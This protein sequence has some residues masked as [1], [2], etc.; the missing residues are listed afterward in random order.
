MTVGGVLEV[1]ITFFFTE[2]IIVYSS[3]GYRITI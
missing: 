1:K 3:D 2:N